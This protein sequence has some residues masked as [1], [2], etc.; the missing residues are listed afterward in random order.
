MLSADAPPGSEAALES[1]PVIERLEPVE[2]RGAPVS[3]FA[4]ATPARGPHLA[5][6]A[7]P[8]PLA[9]PWPRKPAPKPDPKPLYFESRRAGVAGVNGFAAGFQ[10]DLDRVNEHAQAREDI[11]TLRRKSFN[12]LLEK[13]PRPPL[14]HEDLDNVVSY[15][16]TKLSEDKNELKIIMSEILNKLNEEVQ[17]FHALMFRHHEEAQEAREYDAEEARNFTS[18]CAARLEQELEMV[19]ISAEE[20]LREGLSVS[21]MKIQAVQEVEWADRE[22]LARRIDA[23]AAQVSA[24]AA[25]R[26]TTTSALLQQQRDS[27]CAEIQAT[28]IG[29][30]A[31]LERQLKVT[32]TAAAE[33]LGRAVEQQA[34]QND[35]QNARVE[36]VHVGLLGRI[37]ELDAQLAEHTRLIDRGNARIIDDLDV[38]LEELRAD[39]VKGFSH[40]DERAHGLCRA[41]MSLENLPTRRV[42]WLMHGISTQLAERPGSRMSWFSPKFDAAGV[43]GLQLELRF[44][45]SSRAAFA[46]VPRAGTVDFSGRKA[47]S[48][49]DSDQ[50][51]C[52]LLLYAKEPGLR[53]LCRLFAGSASTQIQHT[54]DGNEAC[55]SGRL[56][57]LQGQLK[58]SRGDTLCIGVEVLEMVR[59]VEDARLPSLGRE[60]DA[61]PENPERTPEGVISAHRYLLNRTLED[62]QKEEQ[63]LTTH[64]QNTRE[65]KGEVAQQFQRHLAKIESNVSHCATQHER[66]DATLATKLDIETF[67]SRWDQV[68]SGEVK[69]EIS[70]QQER[71]CVAL[72]KEDQLI[73][74]TEAMQTNLKTALA[75]KGRG[76]PRLPTVTSRR[77]GM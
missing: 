71:L 49:T 52:V 30:R 60:T 67:E 43:R 4:Q 15:F 35:E 38:K 62:V 65:H 9:A 48:K 14:T 53:L 29:L 1:A 17:R 18:M 31:D 3:L 32:R 72:D 40:A 42:E 74:L 2:T 6:F 45:G 73:A 37:E 24:S 47:I 77:P 20:N 36:G 41:V 76:P 27:L 33:D 75:L 61:E 26:W 58:P 13:T 50:H 46:A 12:A 10:D 7:G 16:H 64:M 69:T 23:L 55:S 25:V 57:S 28:A 56:C 63:R 34:A 22:H 51:D 44:L 70:R 5:T 21:A 59:V 19:R 11:H 39:T 66:I 54:F 68:I 8:A